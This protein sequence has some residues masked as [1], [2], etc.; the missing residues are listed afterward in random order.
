MEQHAVL[1][2]LCN[3]EQKSELRHAKNVERDKSL[4]VFAVL[5]NFTIRRILTYS[6]YIFEHTLSNSNAHLY[7]KDNS[8]FIEYGLKDV[9]A[10]DIFNNLSFTREITD[11]LRFNQTQEAESTFEGSLIQLLE[12]KFGDWIHTI[13]CQQVPFR[14]E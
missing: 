12:N 7:L 9:S 2:K 8:K 6:S 14:S 13:L 5:N 11:H 3:F 4:S 10:N 1:K